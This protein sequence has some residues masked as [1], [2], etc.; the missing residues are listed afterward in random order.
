[1]YKTKQ[2]CFAAC[3]FLLITQLLACTTLKQK[4]QTFIT[5]SIP[6]SFEEAQ[7][8]E[9]RHLTLAQKLIEKN[10]WHKAQDVY[11]EAL[12]RLPHNEAIQSG[13]KKMYQKNSAYIGKLTQKLTISRA[14][15]LD[16]NQHFYESLANAEIKG[17]KAQYKNK[18][19]KN[20]VKIISKQLTNYRN[21]AVTDNQIRNAEYLRNL[22]KQLK[23]TKQS[24]E[25]L[26]DV[27]GLNSKKIIIINSPQTRFEE[28]ITSYKQAYKN[29]KLQLAYQFISQATKLNPNSPEIKIKKLRLKEEIEIKVQQSLSN[30][31]QFYTDGNYE[32]ALE[33]WQETVG[34]DS[35]NQEALSNIERTE[36]ILANLS[37][38]KD[39]QEKSAE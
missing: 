36:K 35:K 18:A 38:I 21:Q 5:P 26:K 31:R 37:R 20:E 7:N 9:R 6:M 27:K 13:L 39:K 10:E 8:L 28:L 15:W 14:L 1:M 11:D 34:L 2:Y 24:R 16:K 30:G 12:K 17:R 19:I 33:S 25:I 32:K 3:V 23:T 29:N 22:A 4:A